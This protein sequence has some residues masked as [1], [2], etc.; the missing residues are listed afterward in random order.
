M[1]QT[2]PL[3]PLAAE[4]NLQL[5][6]VSAGYAHACALKAD[7]SVICWG[8][9]GSGQATPLPGVYTQ[10]STG[11]YHTCA[12]KPN[13]AIACWGD[14]TY[15]QSIVP[16]GAYKQVSAGGYHT[17]AIKTDN[18][19]ACWGWDAFQQLDQI[20]AGAFAQVSAGNL[21]TCALRADGSAACWGWNTDGQASPPAGAYRQIN[22]GGSHTCAVKTDGTLSCWGSN[23]SGQTTAPSGTFREVGAGMSHSCAI[24]ADGSLTCWGSN[25]YGQRN[26]IPAGNFV[27]L[28]AGGQNTCALRDTGTVACWGWNRY[29]QSL[30][31][32][33]VQISAGADHACAV[34][35][36]NTLTC[37]GNDENGESDAPAGAFLQVSAGKDHSCAVRTDGSL[38]CWGTDA[39]HQ[40]DAPSGTFLAVAAGDAH[41]CGLGLNGAITC[42]GDSSSGKLAVPSG[43]YVQVDAGS[44]F[45]CAVKADGTLTCWG[46]DSRRQSE[47]PAGIFDVV[48][49]GGA[50]AC[51]LNI[52]GTMTCWGDNTYGQSSAP[53]GMFAQVSAGQDHACGLR[54]DGS[55]M[56]WGR[57]DEGQ[58]AAPIGQ[59]TQ[60]SAGGNYSCGARL[61]GTVTCWGDQEGIPQ[62]SISPSALPN[63]LLNQSYHAA[64]IASGAK[65]PYSFKLRS[66][67]LPHG[68]SLS[69]D[70]VISG[71]PDTLGASTFGVEA[72]D[73][74]NPAFSAQETYTIS[75]T[76]GDN[77]PPVITPEITGTLGN[78]GWYISDVTVRWTV[79]DPESAILSRTGCDATTLTADTTGTTLTC[80]ATSA[81]GT[82]SKQVTIKL[83]K[84]APVDVTAVPDRAPDHNGWYN[85]AVTFNFTGVDATSGIASCTSGLVYSGPDSATATV[86]GTCTDNAGNT[87]AP[88]Q[89][90]FQYDATPPTLNPVVVPNPVYLHGT[91]E[92]KPN[93]SDATSGLDT[94]VCDP[95]DTSSVGEK[96]VRC[97]AT[98]MAGNQASATAKYTVIYQ[99]KGFYPP[100]D[101]PPAVNIVVAG[102]AIPVKWRLTDAN[103]SPVAGP[104]P[105]F[106]V[107]VESYACSCTP[108]SGKFTSCA[109][110]GEKVTLD[111]KIEPTGES[112][113]YH[114]VWKT[115]KTYAD[116]CQ[117]LVIDLGE[118][119]GFE[120]AALFQFRK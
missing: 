118:G 46:S 103:G 80:T 32:S 63:G 77:T 117:R 26:S 75:I 27:Q 68:L 113:V 38:A 108:T 10:V 112:G 50:Y 79:T 70:G 73:S 98:D 8:L 62:V 78:N 55:A 28:S 9:N 7:G 92:V 17:C 115:P 106:K 13:G 35:P 22:A 56:C 37:W 11:G 99:F 84:T 6:A 1:V 119:A 21:H 42:W 52:A 19:L 30:P 64:L 111:V 36:D 66:G 67:S 43:A 47:P 53:S 86:K 91:A 5:N 29:G 74:S 34:R 96:S 59:F 61:D 25:G 18:T 2:R 57:D 94:V 33:G 31:P 24:R 4:S 44:Q 105:V 90:I 15:G 100:V 102:Q 16:A 88:A 3:S 49:T 72:R 89:K 104:L 97:V 51:A 85:H 12:L 120:H 76:Q 95:V 40:I 54:T 83:D 58:A 110:T 81:G 41:S 20:P 114:F 60:I 82:S 93:A 23:L 48:S 107:T 69:A 65:A 45:T 87:S 101:N 14:N 109:P 116:T 39:S 71:T